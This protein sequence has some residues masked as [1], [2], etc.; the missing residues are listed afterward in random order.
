MFIQYTK[1][2]FNQAYFKFKKIPIEKNMKL[3]NHKKAAIAIA[4]ALF[5]PKLLWAQTEKETLVVDEITVNAGIEG[6]N[7]PEF[8]LLRRL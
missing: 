8:M 7:K 1:A 5:A 2:F 4:V 3:F 6:G